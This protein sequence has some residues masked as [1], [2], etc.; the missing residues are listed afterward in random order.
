MR[1]LVNAICI[2]LLKVFFARRV[3]PIEHCVCNTEV[4]VYFFS[5]VC[6]SCNVSVCVLV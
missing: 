3:G 4:F 6:V 2:A 1:L 5:E